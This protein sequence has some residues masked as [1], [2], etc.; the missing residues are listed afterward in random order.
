MPTRL[1]LIP[2]VEQLAAD[3]VTHHYDDMISPSGLTNFLGTVRVDHDLTGIS[4]VQFPPVSQGHARTAACFIDGRLLESYGVPI[5]HVWRPDRV[6]RRVA[7]PGLEIETFTVCVPGHTSV[8]IDIVVHNTTDAPRTTEIMLTLGARVTRADGAWVEPES[9][10]D[11]NTAALA[12]DRM[13][14]TDAAHSA[15]SVQGVDV[16]AVLRGSAIVDDTEE[17][18]I[19]IG[20][21]TRGGDVTVRLE[22]EP[23]GSARFGYVHAIGTTLAAATA[24]YDVS[25][26]D[27]PG[28]VS[29][30]ER[31]WNAQFAAAVTPGNTEYSGHLPVLDTNNAALHRLYWWGITGVLWFRREFVGNVLGRSYDVVGPSYWGTSTF[32]WDHSLSGAFHALLDPEPLRKQLLHWIGNDPHTHLATSSLTGE[33][34]GRWYSVNDYAM[35]RMVHDYLRFTGDLGFLD[36]VDATGRTVLEHL[37]Q[38]ARAWHGLRRNSPLADYG[39]ID[40]LLECVSTYRHEVASFNAANVWNMRTTADICD[41]RGEHDEAEALRREASDLVPEVLKL[42]RAGA[43]FFAAR[44]PNG[45][46]I[47]VR[48]CYD[49]IT[50][51]ALI[52]DD[53]PPSMQAEMV[54]F[55]ARELQTPTW[56]RS[57]SPWDPDASYSVRPD[58]QWNGAYTTWPAESVRSLV[59]LGAGSVAR[60]WLPGLART[61]NQG[62]PAQAHFVEEAL[63]AING[64]ARKSPPQLPYINDWAESSAGAYTAMLIEAV[65]GVRAAVDGVVVRGG[66]AAELDPTGVLRGFTIGG[67]TFDVHADGRITDLAL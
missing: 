54:D 36:E 39:D 18:A 4:V 44:Q 8:A 65:F 58:H 47:E 19:G 24:A 56:M 51:G 35:T 14:F 6:M 20:G 67:R 2:S 38:W 1:P 27:V 37:K 33:P 62:P 22:L 64:G 9:P 52:T 16:P 23:R 31:F 50:V 45:V 21:M 28:A 12:D 10:S 3:P 42:Y 40:N 46:E 60:D 25:I 53:L 29:E 5:T 49:F 32:M 26:Q 57:L 59:A 11:R 30:S 17:F 48:H 55:F 7:L 15:W 43:G 34:I 13:V 66:I 63:P 61:A 41:L